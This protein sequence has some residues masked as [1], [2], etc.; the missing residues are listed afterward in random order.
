MPWPHNGF[1][2]CE[3]DTYHKDA[4]VCDALARLKEG[5]ENKLRKKNHHCFEVSSKFQH[6][7]QSAF[8]SNRVHICFGVE[9]FIDAYIFFKYINT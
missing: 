5:V 6:L 3:V 1:G 7:V 4:N 8:T 9:H 2:S